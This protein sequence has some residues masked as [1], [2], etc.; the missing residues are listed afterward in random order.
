VVNGAGRYSIQGF[1]RFAALQGQNDGGLWPGG[2]IFAMGLELPC[3][4]L[5]LDP[6]MT[7]KLS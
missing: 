5:R 7:I 6:L 2:S 3:G 1:F 4:R